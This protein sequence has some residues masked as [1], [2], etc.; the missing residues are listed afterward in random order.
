MPVRFTAREIRE[1]YDAIAPR[2]DR[3]EALPEALGL[4]RLRRGLVRQGRGR[5]LE[6]AAGTG[7]NFPHYPPECALTA[8]DISPGML[9]LARS[10]ARRLGRPVDL[11]L[12]DAAAL[13]F[14]DAAF[15]TVVSTMS[16]CTFPDPVA[17]LREMGRVCRPGGQILLL[18]HGRSRWGWLGR[19]QDRREDRH[20]ARL[21]CH[22]NREPLDL[23]RQAGLEPVAARR[24]L[25]GI[26]HVMRLRPAAVAVRP[27]AT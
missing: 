8:V 9:A 21:G 12:M 20:A 17:A 19:L 1:R 3:M 15:D 5:V 10:R 23:A 26:I 16:V 2:F 24:H 25:A 14:P 22:W 13:A 11:A 27:A 4:R 18:E 6:V 7:R